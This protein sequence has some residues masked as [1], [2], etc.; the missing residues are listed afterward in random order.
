MDHCGVRLVENYQQ[1]RLHADVEAVYGIATYLALCRYVVCYDHKGRWFCS[2]LKLIL[3]T[4][5]LADH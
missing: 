2:T 1:P 4:G 3:V 5:N